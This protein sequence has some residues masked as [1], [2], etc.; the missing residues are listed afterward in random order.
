VTVS[1]YDTAVLNRVVETLVNPISFFKSN[2]FGAVETSDSET[3]MFDTVTHKR[4]ITP[5]VSPLV[6]GKVIEG[7]GYAT[8]SFSPAYAK[9]KRVFNPNKAFKRLAGE[10]IGGSLSPE[11]RLKA[12][13]AFAMQDQID[14][15]NRRL[16]V[17]AAESL[18]RGKC[19]IHGDDYAAVDIDFGRDPSLTVGLTGTDKWDSGGTPLDD[20]EAWGD[21]VFAQSGVVAKTVVCDLAA[22]KLLKADPRFDKLLSTIRRDLSGANIST[23]PTIQGIDNVRYMG[24]AGDY[25]FYVYS[26]RYIDPMDNTE[27]PMLPANTVLLLSDQVEGV[28]HYG[29]IRDLKA[30]INPMQFFVKSWEEEDP[31]VRFL[32]MQSAPLMVPYRVN[33]SLAA[34]VA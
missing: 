7:Y 5:F 9:D 2:Y 28:Q 4:R 23:G 32:L 6:Q 16:E 20:I 31:S 14:M 33:A 21:L 13:I 25:E 11:A 1:I 29:A 19:L 27:K 8:K 10:K 30:G 22:W 12:S 26:G 15:L 3:I 34:T 17:M 24:Y 18:V